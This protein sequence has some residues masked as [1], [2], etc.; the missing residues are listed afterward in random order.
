M[1]RS[2]LA[3]SFGHLVL[4]LSLLLAARWVVAQDTI[5]AERP[6]RFKIVALPVLFYTP[7]TRFGFGA[8][9]LTTFNFPSDSLY[10]RRSSATLGVVY[11]QL[12]QILI[13]V[14]FQLFPHNADYWINGEVGYFRYIFNFFGTGNDIPSDYIEKYDA[15]FP[16]I[17]LNISRKI[18]PGL[19]AGLRY[20]FDDFQFTRTDE[21]GI[22][23]QKTLS[24]S[25]GGLI[26]G[27]GLGINIDTRNI[28]FFPSK[29]WFGEMSIYDE[30]RWSGSEFNYTRFTFDL[31]H[32]VQ[33][34]KKGIVALNAVQ[35]FSF[36][37]V[38]FHQ[39]PV[40]GGTKRLRGYFEG[41]YRDKH[42]LILQ[43][44]YRRPLFW[45]V[46]CAAFGGVGV[47][48]ESF[49]T[50]KTNN[51][52]YNFGAGLRFQIDKAQKINV[53]ADYGFGH[54]SS[55]FYLTFGEAF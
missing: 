21:N 10:A 9:G 28:Q 40:I 6:N 42:L 4:I 41:K 55:G 52:R 17:R 50:L 24:G 46:G 35:V 14:P 7:D 45:R 34:G 12:K 48:A 47:V 19:Y 15:T 43:S 27:L 30:G 11:T 54:R 37:D 13:Y 25:N 5:S 53:R 16:R 39:M 18:A 26:S 20:A 31:A 49:N 23:A 29:G 22:L 1:H 8:G 44:E 3:K 33:A 51:I 36:G 32:Y 2:L 38:P